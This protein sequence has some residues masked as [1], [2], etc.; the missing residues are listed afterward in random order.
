MWQSKKIKLAAIFI[1]GAVGVAA[2][3][4]GLWYAG[5]VGASARRLLPL[6][7]NYPELRSYYDAATA[8]EASIKAEPEEAAHYLSASLNWKTIA[9]LLPPGASERRIFYSRALGVLETGIV[10]FGQKNI[11]FYLNAGH[12][13]EYLEDYATAE[14]YFKQAIGRSPGDETGYLALA[15]LYRY[16]LGKSP[17]EVAAVYMSGISRIP[18]PAPLLAA[19]ASFLKSAGDWGAALEDYELLSK[20]FPANQAYPAVIQELKAQLKSGS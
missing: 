13:A 19:R 18:E 2:L 9:E 15:D 7:K 1:G 4:G 8:R 12:L 10:K 11:V 16:R 6:I 14:N 17:A 20:K 3:V 5:L